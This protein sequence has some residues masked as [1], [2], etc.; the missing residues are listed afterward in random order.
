VRLPFPER[1][2]PKTLFYFAGGL[3][4]LQLLQGTDAIFSLC[5]FGYILAAG[6]AFNI[7][8]GLNQ[9]S[10]AYVF[11]NAL[12]SV[13]VGLCWKAILWEPAQANLLAPQL[14][15]E[16]YFAGMVMMLLAAFLCRKLRLSRPLLE[17]IL[18]DNKY[19][20][21]TYGCLITGTII[22][23]ANAFASTTSANSGSVLAAL[24][25]LNHFFELAIILGVIHIIRRSGATRSVNMPVLIACGYIFLG[26]LF[27]FSKQGMLAPF[28]AWALAAASQRYRLSRGQ[29]L[30]FVIGIWFVFYYLV[31]YS[32]IGRNYKQ[33]KLSQNISVSLS[34]LTHLGD[35]RDQYL[36]TSTDAY[37]NKMYAFYDS[38]QGFFDRLQMFA[39]DDALIDYTQ[40]FGTFGLLPVVQ[41]FENVVPHFIWKDK[42]M[43]LY[44]NTFAHEIG[45]LSEGDESTGVSFSSSAASFHM[46][47]WKGIFLLAPAM[48]F[49]LFWVFDS[50]CGNIR[51]TP[52]GLL[53]LVVYSHAAPEGDITSIIYM[54]S[55]G[56]FGIAVASYLTAYLMPIIGGV[57]L[58]SARVLSRT[59]PLPSVP[60]RIPPPRSSEA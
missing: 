55:T 38:P 58:P 29:I 39:L 22:A 9:T 14:T 32:Q 27:G 45:L 1:I 54:F 36:N 33:E 11:F 46:Y 43:F 13:I 26:G 23:I 17:N 6:F 48:W 44:G 5:C 51:R 25:Q 52:W 16:V 8:G 59:G 40:K 56:A 3:S 24:N 2:P 41:S 18:P 42:P 20:N 10:G 34:L 47:G 15:I 4:A 60:R 31:P 35:V 28:A 30:S 53:V 12:L 7:A 37:D 19:E 57:F 21:A 50:L 49:L